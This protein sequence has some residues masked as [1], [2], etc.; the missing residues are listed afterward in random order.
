MLD[1]NA[2]S[3]DM[4]S[5]QTDTG[6]HIMFMYT[7]KPHSMRHPWNRPKVYQFVNIYYFILYC[8]NIWEWTPA[9]I[10]T[11]ILVNTSAAHHLNLVIFILEPLD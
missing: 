6:L 5:H 4:P 2:S 1:Y 10:L 8:Y 9:I 7:V 3:H 11:E